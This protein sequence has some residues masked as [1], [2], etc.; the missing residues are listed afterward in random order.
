MTGSRLIQAQGA[1]TRVLSEVG[2]IPDLWTGFL[3]FGY[4]VGA[5]VPYAT[6]ARAVSRRFADP[7]LGILPSIPQIGPPLAQFVTAALH[8]QEQDQ[9]TLSAGLR[10]DFAPTADLKVQ[11]DRVRSHNATVPWVANQPGWNGQATVFSI[12]LDFI[13]G[14][15]R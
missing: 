7:N 3:S 2:S 12:V 5:V 9:R 1:V 15:V 11:V 14:G 10:W 4:R 8:A 13:F 6:Y